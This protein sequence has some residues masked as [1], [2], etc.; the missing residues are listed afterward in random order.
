MSTKNPMFNISY[1]LFVLSAKEGD[2]DNGCII[3]T[4]MQITDNPKRIVIGVNKANY[5]HDMIMKSRKFNVSIL[6]QSAKFDTF[7][8]FGFRSGKDAD[9]FADRPTQREVKMTVF[10]GDNA[11]ICATVET[12]IDLERTRCLSLVDAGEVLND[13]SVL[14]ILITKKTKPAGSAR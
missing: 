4:V 2:K 12:T 8:C 11:Y 9:K 13:L 1:G 7:K 5:T 3:N 6:S 10:D 14:C